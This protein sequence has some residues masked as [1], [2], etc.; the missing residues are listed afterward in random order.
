MEVTATAA[1]TVSHGTSTAGNG[2]TAKQRSQPQLK[3][4]SAGRKLKMEKMFLVMT[5][6]RPGTPAAQWT[7]T[8]PWPKATRWARPASLTRRA[9]PRSSTIFHGKGREPADLLVRLAA[10]EIEGAD[11]DGVAGL[12]VGDLPGA[13]GPEAKNLEEGEEGG[14]VP[15]ADDG[16]GDEDEVVGAG[17]DGVSEREPEGGGVEEDVGVGEEEV[18]GG[19]LGGGDGHGVGSCRASPEG[20]R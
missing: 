15:A 14:L 17:G 19:G 16:G 10:D 1:G 18:I 7:R 5:L 20:A 6:I 4:S 9:R 8:R 13:R 12:R 11:A 3:S 2:R